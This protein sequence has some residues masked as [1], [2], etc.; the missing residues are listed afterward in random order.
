MQAGRADALRGQPQPGP[1][2]AATSERNGGITVHTSALGF[3]LWR[4]PAALNWVFRGV[5]RR[6]PLGLSHE[7]PHFVRTVLLGGHLED[8][9]VAG[10][11]GGQFAVSVNDFGERCRYDRGA[12]ETGVGDSIQLVLEHLSVLGGLQRDEQGH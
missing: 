12:A 8:E 4:H 11:K 2:T 1:R 5:S 6:P 3:Q 10:R 9:L 7:S